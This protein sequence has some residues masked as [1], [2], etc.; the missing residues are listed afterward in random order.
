M[1]CLVTGGAGFIGSHL[2]DKLLEGGHRVGVIDNFSSGIEKNIASHFG[3]SNFTVYKTDI[4]DDLSAVF[5]ENTWDSIFHLAAI[6]SVQ[7]S[8]EN[9]ELTHDVNVNGTLNLLEAARKYNVKRFIFS[10]SAAV[11]GDQD[12]LPIKEDAELKPLSPYA[13]HKVIGEQYCTLY[14]RLYGLETVCL[15]YFNVYG[16]RQN[17]DG[18]YASLIPKCISAMSKGEVFTINGD[19]SQ[20]RDF[21]FVED[22]VAA[23]MKAALIDSPNVSGNAYNIGSGVETSVKEIV[24]IIGE[25]LKSKSDIIYGPAV[26]E[27]KK[28]AANYKKANSGFKWK[29]EVPMRIG[30][31]KTLVHCKETSA[32]ATSKKGDY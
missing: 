16:P 15:R 25:L 2:V 14:N 7:L 4:R 27:I 21:I 13:L 22:I 26:Q 11:Y 18:G 5:A 31:E 17:P 3:D 9:P 10:S 12:T 8:I 19:G 24:T 1:N 6:P 23:N 32:Y 29:P 30:L 20:T 28:S